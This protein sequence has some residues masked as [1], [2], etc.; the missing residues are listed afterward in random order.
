M[1]LSLFLAYTREFGLVQMSATVLSLEFKQEESP[2]LF[3]LRSCEATE[4]ST[5]FKITIQCLKQQLCFLVLSKALFLS[6]LFICRLFN[7]SASNSGY[8]RQ[9]VG[10]LVNND[11]GA[12]FRHPVGWTEQSKK[13]SS[14]SITPLQAYFW[15]QDLLCTKHRC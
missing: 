12:E 8:K 2:S 13:N 5:A 3:Q 6:E 9:K 14:A 10:W 15:N 7:D 1:Q 4:F 11:F